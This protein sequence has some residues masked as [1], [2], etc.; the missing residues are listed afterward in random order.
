MLR[1]LSGSESQV[2]FDCNGLSGDINLR[3][4]IATLQST[5][6]CLQLV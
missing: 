1:L 5:G 4:W 3:N 6:Q 2:L